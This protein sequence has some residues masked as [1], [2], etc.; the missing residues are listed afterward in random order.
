[1]KYEYYYDQFWTFQT[2][3]AVCLVM[4]ADWVMSGGHQGQQGRDGSSGGW[5]QGGAGGRS[6]GYSQGGFSGG[7]PQ[8]GGRSYG[9]DAGGRQ[10]A[11]GG[12]FYGA[13]FIDTP[14]AYGY[15]A[16]I[17]GAQ[18]KYVN[19]RSGSGKLSHFNHDLINNY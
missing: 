9:G 15:E 7:W 14:Q 13:N 8:A 5:Q 2:L 12:Q 11:S 1:M 18:S 17:P 4:L 6:G 19:Y 10:S 16:T 3:S